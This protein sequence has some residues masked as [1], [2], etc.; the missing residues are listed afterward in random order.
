MKP[1]ELIKLALVLTCIALVW[2]IY[3]LV[4]LESRRRYGPVVEHPS[5][6]TPPEPPPL[7]APVV[8]EEG[9]K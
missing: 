8:E 1:K 5:Y 2:S 4:S 3:I 6:Y 7:P 9:P